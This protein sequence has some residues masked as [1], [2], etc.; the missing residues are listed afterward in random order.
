MDTSSF[1]NETATLTQVQTM[2]QSAQVSTDMLAAQR[3]Q[4]ASSLVGHTV[5]YTAADGSTKTGVVTAA[6]I[7]TANPTLKIG[8]AD[9][10]LSQIQQ[11]LATGTSRPAPHT[12]ARTHNRSPIPTK[13]KPPCFAPCS[14]A[15]R[16]CGPTSRCST[17]P[18]TT[19][20]TS[21]PPATRAPRRSSR[22]PSAR[23]SPA[24]ARRPPTTGGTNPIQVGLGVQ[25]A[26]T[27][28]NFAQG[29]NQ[30]T[31][32]TSD[33]LINGDGFFVLNNGGQQTYTRAGS[34]SLD[35]AGHL[36]APDGSIVQSA[37]GGNLNLS[38]LN[39][40]TYVSW[41]ISPHGVV[42]GVDAT[43]ATTALGTIATATFANPGGLTKVGDSQYQTS[44]NSGR[45]PDRR[46]RHRRPRHPD[47][48]ATWRCPTS[49]WP[50]S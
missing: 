14:P 5:S 10:D 40:G 23:P 3:A 16:A 45:G 38:A 46:R 49:T 2:E 34:F 1:M 32:R 22:T 44:A 28:T 50:P 29:S 18:P 33:L 24:P 20:P 42:N 17:S 7:S 19:S 36:V 43:G 26:G 8:T 21:T 41:S 47:R 4:T 30:Y 35:S 37:A 27:A 13:E 48:R 11:V 6:T 9:V 12:P 31:G 39:S 25:L 15:S